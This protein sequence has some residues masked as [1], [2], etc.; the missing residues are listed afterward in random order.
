MSA[1]GF[2]KRR[3][4]ILEHI[5]SGA[6]D[7]LESGIHD[8]LLLKANLLIG[9]ACSIP[10]GVCFTSAP[11]IHAH[12]R[13]VSK[14]T[15][16]RCLEHLEDI[17]LLKTWKKPGKR[18][19]FPVLVCRASVHDVSGNEYRIS[20]AKTIDWREPVYEP[21]AE[22]SGRWSNPVASL[23]GHREGR[24]E[25]REKK[26]RP[27]AK[28]APPADPRFQPFFDFA[29]QSLTT[30]H[31][32]KPLWQGKNQN[33]LKN[34]LKSQSADSLPLE[35]LQAIWCN[36]LASTELF[37][38]KQGGSLAYFC[39]NADKFSDGPILAGGEKNRWKQKT[40]SWR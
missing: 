9:S 14:R 8:Y 6:I 38:V 1:A 7:L 3:R 31:G 40:Y 5:D 30:K 27:A 26:E 23:S 29:F 17:G 19:N 13:R 39:S 35:R 37:T 16:Q 24:E 25:S 36:F 11:A 22:L 18:G 21:V 15:I 4:G 32:R 10:V 20:G 33:G 2:Y 34:L 12:C 28:P